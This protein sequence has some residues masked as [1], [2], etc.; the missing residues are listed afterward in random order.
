MC[1]LPAVLSPLQRYFRIVLGFLGQLLAIEAKRQRCR[2]LGNNHPLALV[3]L[4][5]PSQALTYFG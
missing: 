3:I 5:L 2:Q 4:N 1:G